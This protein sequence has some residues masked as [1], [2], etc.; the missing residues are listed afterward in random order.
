[1]KR[2]FAA[3]RRSGRIGRSDQGSPRSRS[4]GHSRRR[5]GE[6]PRDGRVRRRGRAGRRAHPD[7]LQRRRAR[8][9][10]LRHGARRHSRRRRSRQAR[11]GVRRRDA[12]V[13]AGRAADG[14]GAR[15]R[16]HRDDGHHRQHG[17][18]ADA[19]GARSIWSSSAPTA[20]PPTAT[21]RT[22]SAP[23][24]WPCWRDEHRIPF[25][26]AAPLSTIDL[27]T[28]DGSQIPIEERNA[29]EVTHLGGSQL[30]ADRRA[31][32]QP[33]VRRDAAPADCRHHHRARRVSRAVHRI[34]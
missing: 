21:R 6:L 24:P 8:D 31:R 16:R 15:A 13:P 33:G 12:A 22:R 19:P 28:P 4:R 7:A 14:V 25:Y 1:M 10:R 9:R 30:D 27:Q 23:T 3:G 18:R 2:A 26:V 20:S 32:L 34:A 11:D 5:R 29:R 17:R